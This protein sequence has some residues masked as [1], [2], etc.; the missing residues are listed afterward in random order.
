MMSHKKSMHPAVFGPSTAIVLLLLFGHAHGAMAEPTAKS[1]VRTSVIKSVSCGVTLK[2]RAIAIASRYAI[3]AWTCGDGGGE[4]VL[5]RKADDWAVSFTSGGSMSAKE[6]T[7]FG[8]PAITAN[9]LISILSG[10][11]G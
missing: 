9:E 1:A 11:N 3:A 5:K 7:R 6:L 4:T 8:V 2:F 10:S